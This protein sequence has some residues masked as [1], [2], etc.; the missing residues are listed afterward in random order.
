M[1]TN[2]YTDSLLIARNVLTNRPFMIIRLVADCAYSGPGCSP[3]SHS[4]PVNTAYHHVLTANE[5]QALLRN[6]LREGKW[7]G[8][9]PDQRQF[10]L[11]FKEIRDEKRD[12]H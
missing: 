11:R 4:P 9:D 10:T 5:A 3:G 12:K 8:L 6:K 1:L 7:F 2:A